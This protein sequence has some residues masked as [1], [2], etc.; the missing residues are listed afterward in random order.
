MAIE[1]QREKTLSKHL[2]QNGN[3][4]CMQM[5]VVKRQSTTLTVHLED[6]SFWRW[7][8][9]AC[10]EEKQKSVLVSASIRWQT[11]QRSDDAVRTI[12]C[13][14]QVGTHMKTAHFVDGHRLRVERICCKKSKALK[15]Y[16]QWHN[17]QKAT[18]GEHLRYWKPCSL[19]FCQ[20]PYSIALLSSRR[21]VNL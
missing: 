3:Q 14:A 12:L 21:Q 18:D 8:K 13:N 16:S 11:E 1:E 20:S 4:L 17:L 19:L 9:D 10:K 6:N 15:L 2:R 5:D 7:R